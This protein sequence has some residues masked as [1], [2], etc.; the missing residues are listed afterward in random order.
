VS[1]EAVA[2]GVTAV[3]TPESSPSSDLFF[4]YEAILNSLQLGTAV[5]FLD[6]VGET[7]IIDS[8]AMRKV[9]VGQDMISVAESCAV[10]GFSGAHLLAYVR[11]LIKL[12]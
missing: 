10:S 11:T 3:P 7:R 5:A 6:P 8:K 9:E 4:V 1:D 12:H 2:I